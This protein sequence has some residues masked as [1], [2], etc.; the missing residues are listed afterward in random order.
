MGKGLG[1]GA[2]IAGGVILFLIFRNKFAFAQ[3][4][5]QTTEVP[6]G[7]LPGFEEAKAEIQ[8]LVNKQ[9]LQSGL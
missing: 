3:T 4:F 5:P 2:L 7:R 1:I 8:R 9:R 6:I